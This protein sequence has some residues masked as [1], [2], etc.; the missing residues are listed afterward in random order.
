MEVDGSG[1]GGV[2]DTEIEQESLRNIC[3]WLLNL[4]TSSPDTHLD[5]ERHDSDGNL[6]S[7]SD[8]KAKQSELMSG[9]SEGNYSVTPK[10]KNSFC[11]LCRL[12]VL[13][14]GSYSN[15][16]FH[17]DCISHAVVIPPESKNI[18]IRKIYAQAQ[19]RIFHPSLVCF[20]SKLRCDYTNKNKLHV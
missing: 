6:Q 14:H 16:C 5:F 11:F 2:K 10:G 1:K 15:D 20:S 17:L 4:P 7:E 13:W 8:N 18:L 12:R 9:W 19:V 3:P